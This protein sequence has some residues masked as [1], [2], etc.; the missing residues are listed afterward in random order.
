MGR[1]DA[2]VAAA[3]NRVEAGFYDER[4]APLTANGSLCAALDGPARIIAEL[5]PRSPSGGRLLRAPPEQLL[6]AYVNGG[7][8]A[9][10]VLA[11][12]DF[13][14]GHPDLVRL[15]NGTGLPVLWK[16]FVVDPA[17]V[18]A[19]RHHGASAVLLI[20]RCFPD[21]AAR[22]ALVQAAHDAGL[23]VLL[24][25]YDDADRKRAAAS[26]AEL[27]GVNARD[28]ETLQVDTAAAHRIVGSVAADGRHAV[29]LS[30]ILDRNDRKAAEAA[31]ARGVL[32][33][34]H[35]MT[36]ADPLLALR[37][38][39]R[40]IAKVCGLRDE[41]G[42]AAA[43]A[44]GADLAGFVVSSPGSPRSQGPEEA[45]PLVAAAHA[46]GLRT[47]LVTTHPDAADVAGWASRLG[48]DWV[49]SHRADPAV[50]R[51]A[52]HR[53]LWAMAAEAPVPADVEGLVLDTPSVHGVGGSGAVHDW[54]KSRRVVASERDRMALVA[55]GLAADNVADALAATG[56]W[57]ADASSRLESR[58][59]VK[60]A[61]AVRAYV[62]AAHAADA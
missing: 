61:D 14:D 16:D 27:I 62:R 58:P 51:A 54:E 34:T 19:A 13:F 52:G 29:A 12:P 41:A 24:E 39:Q 33:G 10:S 11:D 56:A 48:V 38:L 36:A 25:V 26:D 35:L 45:A 3:R 2:F 18:E 17:Q 6:E 7:A 23:E 60:D 32:V 15:A 46:A 9:V 50:L 47:V 49:Q 43:A 53:V 44:A 28:L 37:A 59:G 20:E 1:L 5:K 22:E 40:P 4:S 57:G 8:A 42:V 55:G 31:G 21:A 30:G